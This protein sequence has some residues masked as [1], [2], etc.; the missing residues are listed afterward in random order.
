MCVID[1]GVDYNHP[2][3]VDNMWRNPGETGLDSNGNDKATNGIDDD[4]NGVVDGTFQRCKCILWV[5][6][7][8]LYCPTFGFERILEH[9]EYM[10]PLMVKTSRLTI[11]SSCVVRM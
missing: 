7:Q 9:A 8:Y 1:T 4:N 3:L 5:Y 6:L 11:M 10:M 2:D